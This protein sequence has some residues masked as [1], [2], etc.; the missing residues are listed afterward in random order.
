MPHLLARAPGGARLEEIVDDVDR[1]L[2]PEQVHGLAPEEVGDG[3]HGVGLVEGM[4]DR[5][6]IARI[7]PEERRVRAVER[8]HDSRPLALGEHPAGEDRGRRMRDGVMDV[9]DVE[10]VVARHLGHLDRQ[11]QRVVGVLEEPVVV[12]HN[13]VEEDPRRAPWQAERPLV[14]DEVRLVAP[15]GQLL[16]QGRGEDAAAADGRVARDAD[17]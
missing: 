1:T 2:D 12:D 6:A 9:E 4:P 14:A 17:P 8:R 15:A 7:A 13:G 5:G 3:R 10:P 11:R 16:P